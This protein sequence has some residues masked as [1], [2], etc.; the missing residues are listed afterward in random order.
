VVSGD[1]E[2]APPETT[3]TTAA[4]A[5]NGD[6]MPTAAGAS[7]RGGDDLDA[8]AIGMVAALVAVGLFAAWTLIRV[9]PG[10]V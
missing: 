1:L 7:V 5:G 8:G 3:A 10:R 4:P 6:E 9:R 2:A